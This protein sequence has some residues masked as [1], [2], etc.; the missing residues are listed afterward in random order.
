VLFSLDDPLSIVV[1]IAILFAIVQFIE[2]NLL[3]PNIVG[4][5]P[6]YTRTPLTS[7]ANVG[8]AVTA[9]RTFI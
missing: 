4:N 1:K 2:N 7:E 5:N 8:P 3:T 9:A 6:P